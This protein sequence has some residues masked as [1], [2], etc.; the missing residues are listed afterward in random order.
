MLLPVAI[1]AVGELETVLAMTSAGFWRTSNLPELDIFGRRTRLLFVRASVKTSTVEFGL[2]ARARNL[3]VAL[4]AYGVTPVLLTQDARSA[5]AIAVREAGW[6]IIADVAEAAAPG[7]RRH[8]SFDSEIDDLPRSQVVGR[9]LNLFC[10]LWQIRDRPIT[11][12]GLA[13]IA[14]I[15]PPVAR[16]VLFEAVAAGWISRSKRK[17][18]Y[19]YKVENRRALVDRF[20]AQARAEFRRWQ[21]Y[22]V[23]P[24]IFASLPERLVNFCRLTR[25]E[26][27]VTGRYAATHY[28]GGRQA[29]S[30]MRLRVASSAHLAALL[31]HLRAAPASHADANLKILVSLQ[32]A[33]W[34]FR[35]RCHGLDLANPMIVAADLAQT[36]DALGRDMDSWLCT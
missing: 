24:D 27:A 33:C 26:Y 16:Q 10:A 4:E 17:R 31:A 32:P 18:Q 9:Q 35:T 2:T 15:S 5:V 8:P 14:E 20:H 21:C 11:A 28:L 23:M 13:V 3:A 30:E 36:G 12:T 25:V 29:I 22:S 6:G 34:L 19:E 7:N 1:E